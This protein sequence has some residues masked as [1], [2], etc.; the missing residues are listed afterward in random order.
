MIIAFDAQNNDSDVLPLI[1]VR[2]AVRTRMRRR[3][4]IDSGTENKQQVGHGVVSIC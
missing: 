4:D 2:K 3:I 1:L